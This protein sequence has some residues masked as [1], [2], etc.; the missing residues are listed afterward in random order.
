MGQQ[1]NSLLNKYEY[2][3]DEVILKSRPR[4]LFLELTRNCNL[5]CTMCRPY[6]WYK[7]E[8]FLQENVL[9]CIRQELF[10]Y[11]EMVDLRGFGESTLDSR[12]VSIADELHHRNVKTMIYSNMCSQDEKYWEELVHTGINVAVSIETADPIKYAKIRRGGNFELMKTNLISSI[13]ASDSNNT[14]FLTV[15]LSDDNIDDIYGLVE[16]AAECGINK[17]Q[18]NPISMKNPVNPD[19]IS[20]YGF[21]HKTKEY[22]KKEFYK[23]IELSNKNN[24]KV[25]VAANLFNENNI[26]KDKCIHPWSYVFIRYDGSIGF[27]DHLARQD[28]SLKGNINDEGF[29]AIW[30][31]SEYQELRKAH[32]TKGY[33]NLERQRIECRWCDRN[34]YGNCEYIIDNKFVPKELHEYYQLAFERNSSI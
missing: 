13:K 31:N 9:D 27:C 12:L 21:H 18:L 22:V 8:W 33:E 26:M 16:F 7:N 2:D 32:I 3:N 30:N 10:P 28:A 5:H 20:H 19:G 24:V 11:I 1:K 25:E 23:I 17:I 29:M 15:V 14:P 6:N 4:V 34:R